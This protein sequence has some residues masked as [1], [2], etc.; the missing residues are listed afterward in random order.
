MSL[1]PETIPL[2]VWSFVWIIGGLAIFRFSVNNILKPILKYKEN[3]YKAS[4]GAGGSVNPLMHFD[5]LGQV[6]EASENGILV[7]MKDIE[8][9]LKSRKVDPM[10][11]PA[12]QRLMNQRDKAVAWRARLQN[13]IVN[14]LDT[15][16]FPVAKGWIP[17]IQKAGKR[18]FKDF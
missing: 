5:S 2:W 18:F 9:H 16:F 12:Y 10:K 14:M 6:A 1:F 17:E 3:R 4:I 7:Q 11:D 13:P 15:T 8:Q